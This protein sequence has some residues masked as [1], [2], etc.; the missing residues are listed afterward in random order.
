MED[1]LEPVCRALHLIAEDQEFPIELMLELDS[2]LET[3][4]TSALCE[5]WPVDEISACHSKRAE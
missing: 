3:L 2:K 5:E 1:H 4:Y